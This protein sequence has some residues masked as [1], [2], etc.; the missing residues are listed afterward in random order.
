MT[1]RQNGILWRLARL[2]PAWNCV[3]ITT[4]LLLPIATFA[5]IDY[6]GSPATLL[7]GLGGLLLMVL[8]N[9]CLPLPLLY[10]YGTIVLLS[11]RYHS[12]G[13]GSL[14]ESTVA[15][16]VLTV[17]ILG[18]IPLVAI[19]HRLAQDNDVGVLV[20]GMILMFSVLI[21][22]KHLL[23]KAALELVLAEGRDDG[24]LRG[25]LT[26]LA[27]LFWPI[28]FFWI[29][30]RI[31]RLVRE[32]ET[33]EFSRLPLEKLLDSVSDVEE[34]WAGVIYLTSRVIPEHAEAYAQQFAQHIGAFLK[35]R[36]KVQEGVIWEMNFEKAP[37]VLI[38][39]NEPPTF[40]VEASDPSALEATE[41]LFKRLLDRT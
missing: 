26:W 34:T 5:Y 35:K 16:V 23:R 37:L 2:H 4:S 9:L 13:D 31:R 6:V 40:R 10:I 32:Y 19:L 24:W 1:D 14:R 33:G 7:Q 3:L 38:F 18:F 36:R 8:A 11:G 41:S 12:R 30:A 29:Q 27:V 21:S 25:I 22:F 17:V 39:E 15:V 20:V 28:G